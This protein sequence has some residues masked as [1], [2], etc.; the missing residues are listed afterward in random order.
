MLEMIVGVIGL[1]SLVTS[2]WLLCRYDEQVIAIAEEYGTAGEVPFYDRRYQD[3][4]AAKDEA[5]TYG[6]LGLSSLLIGT[7]ALITVAIA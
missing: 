1:L 2:G 3:W 7:I 4:K 5:G 6:M